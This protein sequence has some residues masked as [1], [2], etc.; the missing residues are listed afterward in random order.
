MGRLETLEKRENWV[1][2]ELNKRRAEL[3]IC[4]ISKNK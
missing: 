4:D 3:G 1:S 2:N